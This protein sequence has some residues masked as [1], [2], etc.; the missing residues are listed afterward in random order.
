MSSSG[1][2]RLRRHVGDLQ[3]VHDRVA[4]VD[5]QQALDEERR[6][7]AVRAKELAAKW[8]ELKKW[9]AANGGSR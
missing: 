9:E 6:E 1:G 3:F 7:Q 5:R 2:R 4:L 8:E